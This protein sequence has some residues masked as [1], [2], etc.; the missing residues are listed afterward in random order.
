M[1]HRKVLAVADLRGEPML[2]LEQGL[3]ARAV[4]EDACRVEGV[5]VPAVL[6]STGPHSLIALARAGH[7]IAVVPSTLKFD[8]S[9]VRVVPL[10]AKGKPLGRW[11]VVAWDRKRYVPPSFPWARVLSPDVESFA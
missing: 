5:S 10:V 3:F 8:V 9:G 4:L 6:E 1:A 2:L 11:I 7:G